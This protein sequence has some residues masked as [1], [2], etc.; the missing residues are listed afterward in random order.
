[1]MKM[2]NRVRLRTLEEKNRNLEERLRAANTEVMRM[3]KECMA[4]KTSAAEGTAQLEAQLTTIMTA[5]ISKFGAA[6][7]VDGAKE[8]VL[9]FFDVE[10]AKRWNLYIRPNVE[11]RNM[12]FRIVPVV[13][14]E[15]PADGHE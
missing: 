3:H 1:M 15:G 8:I 6:V 11:S 2:T 14:C 12:V 5:V 4:V 7:G 10:D 13:V 9:P